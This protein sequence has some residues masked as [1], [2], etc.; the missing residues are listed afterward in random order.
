MTK[1]ETRKITEVDLLS[2]RKEG[3]ERARSQNTMQAHGKL[4]EMDVFSWVNPHFDALSLVISLFPFPVVWVGK[5]EQIKCCSTYYPEVLET[6]ESVIVA[7]QG[8]IKMKGSIIDGMEN[9]LGAG[10]LSDA[11]KIVLSLEQKRRVFIF[12]TEGDSVIKD[13]NEF[14]DFLDQHK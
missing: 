14:G 11:L 5:Q 12:T 8:N 10:D 2:A 1:M 7:D 3:L 9:V 6:L 13:M 4:R